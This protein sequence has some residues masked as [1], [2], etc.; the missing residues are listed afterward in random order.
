MVRIET[1]LR[2]LRQPSQGHVS[3]R[4]PAATR[5]CATASI[6]CRWSSY[7]MARPARPPGPAA[8][9]G[10]GRCDGLGPLSAGVAAAARWRP[11][12]A[13]G[14]S[15]PHDVRKDL[16]RKAVDQPISSN[17]VDRLQRAHDPPGRGATRAR[18]PPGSNR[19]RSRHRAL[20]EAHDDPRL[21]VDDRVEPDSAPCTTKSPSTMP[22]GTD[23]AVEVDPA[24]SRSICSRR[25]DLQHIQP[26]RWTIH[27]WPR[28]AP[29]R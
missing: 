17:A 9:R 10:E 29:L 15:S 5:S 12:A 14:V 24:G 22:S 16:E 13:K 18:F 2:P 23:H 6:P 11:W 3:P 28:P 20:I 21:P 7:P 26:V 4:R 25:V 19:R 27:G 8:R 1:N